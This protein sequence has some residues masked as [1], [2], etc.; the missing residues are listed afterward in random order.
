MKKKGFT[1][2]ELLAVIA[3]LAIL[4]IIALPNVLGMF[5]SAKKNTFVT[6]LQSI[7]DTAST[8]FVSDSMGRHSAGAG[9]A[10]SR[11]GGTVFNEGSATAYKRGTNTAAE[12]KKIDLQGTNSI[13]F[14]IEFNLAGKVIT[15]YATDGQYQYVFE[16]A[17]LK[18]EEIV[19][20]DIEGA[21]NCNPEGNNTHKVFFGALGNS[22][23][24]TGVVTISDAQEYC[25]AG[26]FTKLV[27]NGTKFTVEAS[28]HGN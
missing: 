19:S 15:Y 23:V 7:Y 13:D 27:V 10:Y 12:Y 24:N 28:G 17:D 22:S 2:V 11:I 18:K 3:I 20:K 5:N 26:K 4:V 9:I 14:Y 1:L 8:Q 25:D 21:A 6:E 16:G